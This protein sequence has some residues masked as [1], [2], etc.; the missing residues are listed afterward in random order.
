MT[1]VSLLPVHQHLDEQRLVQQGLVNYWGYNSIGFFCPSP[2][3]A[4]RDD[5]RTARDE[6]N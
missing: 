3:L 5:G 6:A 4:T 1:S 2:R